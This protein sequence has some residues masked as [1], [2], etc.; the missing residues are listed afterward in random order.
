M[1]GRSRKFFPTLL[2]PETRKSW[3]ALRA[4][5][6]GHTLAIAIFA[7]LAL[8]AT[9][10]FTKAE[11][12]RIWLFLAPLVIL[13]AAPLVRRTQLLVAVLA[14]QAVGYELLFDTL[15]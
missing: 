10:G 11:T 4:L 7:I 14:V 2:S 13:C 1:A 9:L 15:W 8:S 3:S 5:A 12:E 6:A